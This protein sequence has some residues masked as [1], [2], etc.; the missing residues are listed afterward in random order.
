MSAIAISNWLRSEQNYSEGCVLFEQYGTNE[1]LK[2]LLKTG[3]SP[4][5]RIKLLEELSMLASKPSTASAGVPA[6]PEKPIPD[7]VKQLNEDRVNLFKQTA[8]L[9]AQLPLLATNE[10][11]LQYALTIKQ[12]FRLINQY[13]AQLR[14]FEQ[15]GQLPTPPAPAEPIPLLPTDPLQMH[16]RLRN[17]RTY[18]CKHRNN[19]KRADH[20]AGWITERD[21]LERRLNNA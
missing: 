10:E 17:V 12:N 19:P 1:P 7:T 11:R 2:R 5:T 4:F 6:Q 13:W 21:E 20:V 18:I 16:E 15:T 14:Q 9:H 8:R 3:E